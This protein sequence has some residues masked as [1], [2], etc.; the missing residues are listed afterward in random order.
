MVVTSPGLLRRNRDFRRFWTGHTLSVAGTHVTAVALP[1]LATLTMD[2]GAA[3]VAAIAT[4]A[5]LPNLLLPL[6][7]GHW[8][9][10]RRRRRILVA[11]DLARAAVLLVVPAAYLLDALSVPLLVAVAFLVGSAS[12]VFEIG[13]FAYVPTLVDEEDLG[14]ANRDIQGSSTAAQ[15]AG[16]GL[17]GGLAQLA[18]PALA[19]VID[20]LSY[21]ASAIGVAGARR[22]EPAPPQPEQRLGIFSGIR[23]IAANPFLRALTAHAMLYN[24]AAQILTVNL[25]VYAVNDRGLS[26]GMYGLALSASGAGAFVGTMLALRLAGRFGFGHAFA[27]SLTFSTGLPLL[28]AL[29]PG[30]GAVLASGFTAVMFAAGIGLGSANVLSVTLRQVVAPGALARTNGGYRVLTFGV[31]PLGSLIGGLIGSTADSRI[32]VAVG[33]AG[34]AI[35]AL[36]MFARRIR[37]LHTPQD[38]K[39]AP[40]PNPDPVAAAR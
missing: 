23:T 34:L 2:A 16:P 5:Y 26:A 4:A 6:L 30:D 21:L 22:S 10:Q 9:E 38:A 13:G 11:T 19:I 8:L 1:L 14:A 39:P 40:T 36:P 15:V 33:T 29:L 3:G 24:G 12:V 17:A 37:A 7:V 35:S 18:G 20:A 28:L 31:L 27:M 25:I 32:G